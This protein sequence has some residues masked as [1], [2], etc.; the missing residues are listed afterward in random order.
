MRQ[1]IL[2]INSGSA[3]VKFSVFQTTADR[4]LSPAL[5]GEVENIGKSPRLTIADA[6]G[7]KLADQPVEGVGHE[8]AIEAIQAWF[9]LHVGSEAGFD[10]IGHRV[11]HGGRKYTE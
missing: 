6:A 9:A 2:V 8:R 11:V 5:H 1:P 10:G 4:T 3:S 7:G